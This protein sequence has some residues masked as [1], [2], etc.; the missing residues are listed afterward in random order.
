MIYAL[1]SEEEIKTIP[2]ARD[3][4]RWRKGLTDAEHEAI[5]EALT[6]KISD[7][8]VQTSSWMPG[9]S[10]AN[11]PYEPIYTKAC[12]KSYEQA[13]LFFGQLV[14]EAF[15]NHSDYWAFGRY[16]LND[17]PLKG[18]TYFKVYPR[19]HKS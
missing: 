5:L 18:L 14:W 9:K 13:A 4:D 17:V 16:T 11:T 1:D 8:E 7:T 10:W 2:H 3:Y 19:F 15:M 12:N 6:K